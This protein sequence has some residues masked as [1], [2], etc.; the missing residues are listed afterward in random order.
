[1][2]S[3]FTVMPPV[4]A[5]QCGK[6][7]RYLATYWLHLHEAVT[8]ISGSQRI[9]NHFSDSLTFL[10]SNGKINMKFV[11]DIHGLRRMDSDVYGDHLTFPVTPPLWK[12]VILSPRL[13]EQVFVDF[14]D[15]VFGGDCK[16]WIWCSLLVI[17]WP[18]FV[19]LYL[20]LGCFTFTL[21]CHDESL[22]PPASK[23]LQGQT[24][25]VTPLSASGYTVPPLMQDNL[26]W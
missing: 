8:D 17:S 21:T 26:P 9:P 19:F 12:N 25:L 22:P 11:L 24:R 1:M 4:S 6:R 2:Q 15:S 18:P 7:L 5:H 14:S 13:L 16:T 20:T 23:W 10:K 3:D